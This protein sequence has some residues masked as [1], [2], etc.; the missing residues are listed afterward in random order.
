[1][2][3]SM[4]GFGSARTIRDDFDL[5]VQLKSVNHRFSNIYIRM[6]RGFADLENSIRSI[7]AERI[8]R[9]K[10]D[11]FIEIYSLPKQAQDF[12]LNV[13]TVEKIMEAGHDLAT[14]YELPFDLTVERVL[15]FPDVISLTPNDAFKT[16]LWQVMKETILKAL[17]SL[18]EA[19][20]KEGEY[21]AREM[22]GIAESIQAMLD[23]VMEMV[24]DQTI[25]MRIKIQDN[26]E[27]ILT[28]ATL[29]TDRLEQEVAL[30]AMRV[31]ISEEII[32]LGGHM[33]SF[34]LLL[35]HEGAIG[36]R[37]EFLVQ[38]MHREVNTMGSKSQIKLLS[39]LVVDMK[40]AVEKIREQIQ[41]IM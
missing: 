18:D 4:T 35:K 32:R 19:R 23:R 5:M 34:S 22:A 30:S 1:M 33:S 37:A 9:G 2:A 15:R 8:P 3:F 13:G 25:A 10:I 21:L 27:K 6:P 14:K 16:E 11:V 24:E 39:E 29:N 40:V 38:E 41:N 36:K 31:D 28:D 12:S 26:L 17:D 7:L 20:R